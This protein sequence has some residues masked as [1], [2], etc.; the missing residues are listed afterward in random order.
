MAPHPGLATPINVTL[1]NWTCKEF[2]F[3][4]LDFIKTY[5]KRIWNTLCNMYVFVHF[6]YVHVLT[7]KNLELFP[8][9]LNNN[10]K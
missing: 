4:T 6:L 1:F 7:S 10:Q 2:F 5:I 9:N 8:A 3:F